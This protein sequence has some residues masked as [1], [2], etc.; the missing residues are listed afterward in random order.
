MIFSG[1]F[2]LI[3]PRFI[4]NFSNSPH[5]VRVR[6][7][8]NFF[9]WTSGLLIPN[10]LQNHAI[11][12][13]NGLKFSTWSFIIFLLN[14]TLLSKLFLLDGNWGA[15]GKITTSSWRRAKLHKANRRYRRQ[16]RRY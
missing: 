11:T 16:Y 12:S 9:Q 15:A 3:A 6:A 1:D 8:L 10:H 2:G 14:K 4:E 7:I 5:Y 13:T